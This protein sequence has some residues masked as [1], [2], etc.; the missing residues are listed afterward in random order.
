MPQIIEH[1]E[2]VVGGLDTPP[3]L[4]GHSAGGVFTQILLDHG[5]GAAGVAINSAP[6]EGVKVVPLSQ[7]KA[8]F[9]VLK[10]PANR[11]RAV[12][13]HPRAVAVRVHQHLQRG[14]VAPRSTSATTSRRPAAILWGSVLAN[15]HPG[16]Q[17][18]TW[19]DYKNHDRAPLL[20][21]SGSEDHLM[22]PTIQQSNAKHYKATDTITEVKEYRRAR[23]CCP[24]RTGWEEV[25]D[26]APRLGARQRATQPT[27]DATSGSPTSAGRRSCI[28]VAGLADPHR[29]D[30]RRRRA[31]PT[32]SAGA[33]RPARS[34]GPAV[35][36]ADLGPID[37]VLLTH[38]HHADNLD[39]A[40]RAL[41]PSAGVVV[42]TVAGAARLG[43]D[44]RGL[45]AVGD[46]ARSRHRAGR[47]SRS[48]RRRAATARRC[49]RPIVGDVIGFALRVGRPGA[50]RA[51][52]LRRHRALRRR[53]RGRRPARGRHRA[54]CTSAACSSRSPDR[55]ATR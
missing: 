31:G 48:R 29:P 50:R 15:I 42:T 34:P 41:L 7:V 52:D 30:V 35:A 40:G 19:V 1:L 5:F 46:D 39:D 23:T 6:T 47:R 18:D 16:H 21:I 37:A 8:T 3:I 22:P 45:A 14:G 38:D 10:N 44:A 4:M 26:Y 51:V 54:C 43:G 24:P 17:D 32:T 28:E 20:F 53:A 25:A 36:A 9:P 12:G 55:C 2:A 27:R 49:S 13:L 33:R 11:H